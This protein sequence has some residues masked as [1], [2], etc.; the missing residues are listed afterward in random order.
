VISIDNNV[1]LDS[2][3]EAEESTNQVTGSRAAFHAEDDTKVT[4]GDRKKLS[5]AQRKK[6]AKE[7]KKNQR[8]QNKGRRFQKIRDELN[9]CWR[10]A[11]GQLCEFGHE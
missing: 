11:A 9:L 1:I 7:Q 4:D 2:D 3:D 8:G 10:I 5:G 6:L